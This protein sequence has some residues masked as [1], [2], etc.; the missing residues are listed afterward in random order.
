MVG[1]ISFLLYECWMVIIFL[2]Y[3]GRSGVTRQYSDLERGPYFFRRR[4]NYKPGFSLVNISLGSLSGVSHD[5]TFLWPTSWGG[6][7]VTVNF[8]SMSGFRLRR[9]MLGEGGND[10]PDPG[11]TLSCLYASN[12]LLLFSAGHLLC[13]PR[14]S[15]VC[16]Y[17]RPLGQR[18]TDRLE[19]IRW[20]RFLRVLG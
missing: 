9:G 14:Y 17:L 6:C 16:P 11:N 10:K 12:K 3:G 19:E 13:C 7:Y 4:Q 18:A 15:F 8:L 20:P 2:F 5:R 1:S